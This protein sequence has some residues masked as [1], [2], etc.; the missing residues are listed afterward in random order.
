MRLGGPVFE[1]TQSPE[2]WARAVNFLG[3]RA[4]YCP[5]D[6]GAS[7]DLVEAYARAAREADIVIAEVGA[8]SNPLSSDA[9][10]R[11]KAV[12]KCRRSL[13]LAE[14]IGARCCVNIAGSRGEQWDGPHPANLNEETFDMIVE[15]TRGIID[16][17]Q[18]K[19]TA[20]AL[21]TMPWIFPDSPENYLRLIH[22]IDRTGFAVHLD[23]VNMINSPS[24]VY[25]NTDFLKECFRLL[26][27]HIRGCHAK[28]IALSGALT[29]HLD[30][31][32]PGTGAL[33]YATFL[34]E[35]N[36][37][38]PDTPLM[39]EHLSNEEDYRTAA[40]FV[41]GVANEQGIT[42]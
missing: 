3:Y 35:L 17:V 22:A 14:R 12:D 1:Q 23:P 24:R 33:D 21:E 26:G 9:E 5:V 41:R 27:P 16:A 13:D 37:L 28:D 31:V 32:R 34:S 11:E 6:V 30:E 19:H 36:V 29:V 4:A 38:D 18:P 40:N 25:Y 42:L 8:W 20:F 7:D 39:L 10:E 2:E 15:T